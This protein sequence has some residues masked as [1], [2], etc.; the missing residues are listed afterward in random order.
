MNNDY[1]SRQAVID[2]MKKSCN[3][4]C[5]PAV[6]AIPTANVAEVKYGKWVKPSGF[7]GYV[8]SECG[9]PPKTMYEILTE[10]CPHCGC[11]MELTS[12]DKN[13]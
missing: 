12:K 9:R 6:K 8:C 4:M 1:I 11:E 2:V 10:Y 13:E 7:S 5:V 3:T